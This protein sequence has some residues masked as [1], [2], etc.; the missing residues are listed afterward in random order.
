MLRDNGLMNR[1]PEVIAA[2]GEAVQKGGFGTSVTPVSQF[3]FQQAFNNVIFGKWKKIA[4]GYGKMVLGYFGKTPVEPDSEVVKIAQEQIGLPPTKEISVDIND[5]DPQKGYGAAKKRLEEKNLPITDEN[6]F[7][8]A[9]C[10]EKG[11]MFLEGKATIGVR[12]EAAKKKEAGAAAGGGVYTVT[13]NSVPYVVSMQG[14][15]A[16]VNG[17]TYAVNVAE[18]AASGNPAAVSGAPAAGGGEVN[19]ASPLPGL[20]LRLT[21]KV[22]DAVKEGDTILVLES[23]KMETPIKAPASGT[24]T[25]ISVAQGAQVQT[26]QT[27]A[28]IGGASGGVVQAAPAAAASPSPAPQAA[29]IAGGGLSIESPLPGLILRIV[30]S[31]GASLKA[32]DTILVLE[33]MK[34]ETPIKAPQAGV[35]KQIAVAQGAQVQTGQVLA[36]MG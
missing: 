9:A 14:A 20:I 2:M 19:V 32:G 5:R 18:G 22:G 21:S 31:P 6:I 23:M 35:L 15:S 36:V 27:L 3:Y 12:K 17:V 29:P 1:Y 30:A 4:P 11:I 24:I 25:A 10:E 16:V 7:I 33:S 28:V 8:A 26:G 13:V 34:M